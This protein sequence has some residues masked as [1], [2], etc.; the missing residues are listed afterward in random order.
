DIRL[1]GSPVYQ[2]KSA[3][4]LLRVRKQ[5]RRFEIHGNLENPRWM[6][7]ADHIPPLASHRCFHNA[8][9]SKGLLLPYQKVPKREHN[10]TIW[11]APFLYPFLHRWLSYLQFDTGKLHSVSKS[12]K[13]V[14]RVISFTFRDII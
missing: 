4:C 6:Y 9:L 10:E 13:I 11:N 12:I 14:C 3:I 1:P 8:R 2:G 7:D 5:P